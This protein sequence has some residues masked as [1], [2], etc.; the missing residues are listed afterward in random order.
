MRLNKN[1]LNKS[2]YKVAIEKMRRRMSLKENKKL[3]KDP[4]SKLGQV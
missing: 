3:I 4:H 2:I 1:K